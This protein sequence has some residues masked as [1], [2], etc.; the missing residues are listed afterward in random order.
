MNLNRETFNRIFV[1]T[2][3]AACFLAAGTI[4]FRTPDEPFWWGGFLRAGVVLTV[5]WFCL[6]ARGRRAAWSG[7]RPLPTAM[8]LLGLVLTVVRPKLGIPLLV[9][10][11]A[12]HKLTSFF[13]RTPHTR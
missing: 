2:A 10:V 5:L 12:F 3:A 7:L 1:A 13:R 11:S 4:A 6:P 8:L 9:A